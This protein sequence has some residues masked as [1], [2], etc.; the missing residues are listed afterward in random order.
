MIERSQVR[1]PAGAAGELNCLLQGQLS[2]LTL[3]LVSVP[4]AC[5]CSSTQKNSD[6]I[7]TIKEV[8]LRKK[9]IPVILPKVQMVGYT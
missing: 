8:T 4:P 6:I 7:N 1:V 3:I 9:K 2:L 5:Y